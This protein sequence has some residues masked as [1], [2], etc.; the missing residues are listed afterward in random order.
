MDGISP[1]PPHPPLKPTSGGADLGD[2]AGRRRFDGRGLRRHFERRIIAAFVLALCALVVIDV[3]A[4]R[5]SLRYAQSV[6]VVKRS[7]R[8]MATLHATLA[9][10]ISAES[11]VRGF[12]ITGDQK[13]LDLYRT[14]LAEVESDLEELDALVYDPVNR[15]NLAEFVKLARARTARLEL[16]VN[17]R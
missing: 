8:A 11:E 6:D 15:Q 4:I 16:T 5:I 9:D 1:F 10:L 12:V 14:S 13:F 3:M 17:T 7:Y 2:E